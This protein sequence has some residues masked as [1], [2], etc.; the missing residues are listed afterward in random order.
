MAPSICKGSD[1][2]Q[3]RH[4]RLIGRECAAFTTCTEDDFCGARSPSLQWERANAERLAALS[5]EKEDI[6]WGA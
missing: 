2:Y 1:Y 6:T 5:T 3:P 4:H